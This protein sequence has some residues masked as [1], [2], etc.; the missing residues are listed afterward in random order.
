M[1]P[2]TVFAPHVLYVVGLSVYIFLLTQ[3]PYIQSIQH[4]RLP[5]LVVAALVYTVVFIALLSLTPDQWLRAET[6]PNWKQD[7]SK[8]DTAIVLGFGYE[9][10]DNGAMQAGQANKFLLDWV[11]NN[12]AANTI[13]VQEGVWAAACPTSA[14]HCTFA[15]R[16]VR[17]IHLHDENAYLN[18]LDTAFCA[19][20]QMATFNKNKAIL[21]TH[22][23]QLQRAAWDFERVKQKSDS[24]NFAFVL[25]EI[26]DTPY[27]ANSVHW[28]TQNQFVYKIVEL[29]ISRPRDFLSPVPDQC[30]SPL[31]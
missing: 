3:T 25:P 15:G 2:L 14:T 12:T 31:P 29:L 20:E 28:Q 17:R 24:L 26:P 7:L 11:V 21:V 19:V 6:T 30:K 9:K 22:D 13:F 27:P 4:F 5:V 23:L 18:T 10:D 16:E 8:T 1:S